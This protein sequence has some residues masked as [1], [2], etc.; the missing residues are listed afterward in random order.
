[1]VD[2]VTADHW[3]PAVWSYAAVMD[4]QSRLDPVRMSRYADDWRGAVDRVAEVFVELNHQLGAQL[5]WSWRGRGADASMESLR[6]YVDGSLAGLAACRSVAVQLSE[7]STAAGELRTASGGFTADALDDVL[8]EVR[9]RYSG[10]AVAAGNAVDDIPAPPELFNRTG[11]PP[12]SSLPVAGSQDQPP[13][14]APPASATPSGSALPPPGSHASTQP[15]SLVRG[16]DPGSAWHSPTPLP[17]APTHSA[18]LPERTPLSID[19][20]AT[21]SGPP[22]SA[23]APGAPAQSPGVTPRTTTSPVA[24]YLSGM[25][26]GHMG[27]DV[28]GEHRVPSYLVSAGNTSELIG[29]LPLV[30]PPVI[31]E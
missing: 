20:P 16:A 4:M 9:Y 14:A 23:V 15:A 31:G 18:A 10:P 25:Y 3:T 7:L 2:G 28:G 19:S 21:T 11:Q 8:A 6:R 26:P 5:D 12:G 30:A 22:A 24:P 1:M 27:R 13:I 17:H 29:E